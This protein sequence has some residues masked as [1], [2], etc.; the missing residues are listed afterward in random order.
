MKPGL[1]AYFAG[2]PVAANLLMLFLIVGGLIAGANLAV[3][4]AP[5][6]EL[7]TVTVV[8]ASH[9]ASP[10]EVEDDI[11]RRIE[12]SV[13]GL[14]G[15]SR[16]VAT[17]VRGKGTV[18]VEM[19]AFA[20]PD[21]VFAEVQNAVDEIEN[22]PPPGAD[23]P[24]VSLDQTSL[25]VMTL[26]VASAA[27]T[28]NSLR[29]AAE[30]LRDTLLALP[31]VTQVS[32][33]GTRDREIA[34]ALSEEE[35]RRHHLSF[36]EITSALR[37]ASVNLTSGELRT[38]AGEVVL[39]IVSKRRTGDD[40]RDIPLITRLDGSILTLGEVAAIHDGLADQDV[41]ATVN[42]VPAIFVRVDSAKQQSIVDMAAEI[43]ARLAGFEPP[44]GVTVS[45]WN[46]RA[47]PAMSRLSEILRNAVIGIVLVF[48][49]LM[50]VFDLRVAVWIAVGIPLSFIGSLLF[51]AP[52]D[53]TLNMGTVF[54]F[55]LLIGIVVDDAV[56]VGESIAA[57]RALG[58]G[59][60][61][62]AVAGAR[63]VAGPITIGAV[64]T[65]LA[66]LPFMF[67]N[68]GVY[69]V[70]KVLT[71]VAAFVLVVSLVEA[72]CILPAHLAHERPWSRSPLADLQRW[73]SA[74]LDAVRDGVVATAV[75]WAVRHVWWTVVAGGVLVF[76]ALLLIRSE[77]VR[78][79]LLDEQNSASERVQVDLRLAAGTPFEKTLATANRFA[80]AA[81]AVNEEF[82][83]TA[84]HTVSVVAG[85]T[86]SSRL[87]REEA[88]VASHV[89][90][91]RANL[92]E[93]P[94][95]TVSI[96]EIEQAWRRHIGDHSYLEE[97][98]F[99]TTRIHARP[100]VAYALKHDDP[101]T[102]QR[103]VGELRAFLETVPGVYQIS[104]SLSLG[105][106]HFEIELTPA[107]KAA[108]LTPTY[109]GAQLRANFHGAV[110]QR[111][112]RGREEIKVMVRYPP[113]RRRSLR[114]LA[115]ERIRRPGG[116]EV[117]LSAVARLTETRE[118]ASRL[119]VDGTQAA[120]VEARADAARITPIQARRHVERE[121][122]PH[123]IGDHPGLVV[124]I[125]GNARN[126]KDVRDTL[127]VLVP[128][129]LFA[130]FA[131]MAGF[132][133]SYW[134]PL[135]AVVGIPMAFS[136]AVFSHWVLGW[137]IT[138]ASLFGV[139]AVAGVVVND[140]LVLLDRYNTIRREDGT[141]PAIA[142]ASAATRNR[143]R[144]VF[145]TSL[146]TVL[147]LSPL[148]Y[149]RSEELR[150]LVPFVASML[151]GLVFATVFTL[152][153]LPALVMIV[154]GRRE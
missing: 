143:F 51:F 70:L 31:S 82:G 141:I 118:L 20:D 38:E 132:L 113:E 50:L 69:Q 104:D 25:E 21:A 57:E 114:E 4:H 60:L 5:E 27:V 97:I 10:R 149:E 23:R 55:F 1:V 136:G 148:L 62:A 47:A 139:V 65:I 35:L 66:F 40:F 102:L 63:A 74:R 9:G 19:A 36:S 26:A 109:L 101:E 116:G 153:F 41:I 42:G 127:V 105:K 85:S 17:A 133:R 61:E 144:A 37:R 146:T 100:D 140:G 90:S 142:A 95:R 150:F 11:N 45:V 44:P 6:I 28:E 103:A 30:D 14:E 108:G 67:I 16:V 83:G 46:D 154:D 68:A 24:E 137:D 56:V 8:V 84:I 39:H 152:F 77:S 3:Q 79:I 18:R 111:V 13:V 78:V 110:V 138:L 43:E 94:P 106:R 99:Q 125:H 86:A 93:M 75:S 123:L 29:I 129:V 96:A 89:A 115:T 59:A 128:L 121:F 92:T 48:V 34:I 112:Q 122:V 88:R 33:A 2:N 124:D 126:E 54:G 12:E 120:L 131:V 151:G 134:K 107:G 81:R 135:V 64:T 80:D 7:R 52:F 22:F 145:L 49:C 98:E 91:V 73:T 147:G 76:A 72:F 87:Q 32:L 53:L 119:R 117:P 71:P 58:K 130:M 15:V